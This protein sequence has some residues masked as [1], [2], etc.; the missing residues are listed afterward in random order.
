[1]ERAIYKIISL[2]LPYGGLIASLWSPFVHAEIATDQTAT[3]TQCEA[4]IINK[5]LEDRY[6]KIRKKLELGFAQGE[7]QKIKSH[8]LELRKRLDK[9]NLEFYDIESNN[10]QEINFMAQN[11]LSSLEDLLKLLPQATKVAPQVREEVV[12]PFTNISSLIA[13]NQEC[14]MKAAVLEAQKEITNS[15]VEISSS[16]I[17]KKLTAELR[18]L[19]E[20]LYKLETTDI[21]R[22][23]DLR[24]Q[25]L[26]QIE[27]YNNNKSIDQQLS[28]NFPQM[29]NS[30][31]SEIERVIPGLELS[32]EYLTLAK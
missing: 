30:M 2:I 17:Y 9:L 24:G 3:V 20:N 15:K 22:F 8:F 26:K 27:N 13:D 25:L 31:Q 12:V 18:D 1:M 10:T 6:E 5:D 19:N 21:Q 28:Q 16:N 7:P 29:I 23:V 11:I 32:K 14:L 4:E